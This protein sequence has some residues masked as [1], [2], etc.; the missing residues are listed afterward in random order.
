MVVKK[1]NPY[2]E[3]ESMLVRTKILVEVLAFFHKEEIPFICLPQSS[4]V[5]T[6]V[7]QKL[8]VA[9][10][11]WEIRNSVLAAARLALGNKK[12]Y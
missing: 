12:S 6:G 5:I 8:S 1:V 2:S 3:N 9:V 11:W 10:F 7:D 4:S